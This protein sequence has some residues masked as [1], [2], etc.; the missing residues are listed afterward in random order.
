M[1]GG[2]RLTYRQL[3]RMDTVWKKDYMAE[4]TSESEHVREYLSMT[5]GKLEDAERE[6]ENQGKGIEG[7]FGSW[8]ET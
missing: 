8:N 1:K 2:G 7:V 3:K 4:I 6:V 5:Q